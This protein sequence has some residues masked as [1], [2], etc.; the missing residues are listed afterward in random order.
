MTRKPNTAL[1][2]G[3]ITVTVLINPA[4]TYAQTQHRSLSPTLSREGAQII[5]RY[6]F[7]GSEKSKEGDALLKQGD[8]D[9]AIRMYQSSLLLGDIPQVRTKL[10]KAFSTKGDEN[11]ALAQYRLITADTPLPDTDIA[12]NMALTLARLR[13][14][15]EA[16]TMYR[17]GMRLPIT[18]DEATGAL[19]GTPLAPGYQAFQS[20]IAMRNDDD[21]SFFDLRFTAA[22]FDAKLFEAAIRTRLGRVRYGS[23]DAIDDFDKAIQL[24]PN[25]APAYLYRGDALKS[26]GRW[27]EAKAMYEKS[28]ALST[29]GAGERARAAL[30]RY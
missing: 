14:Y 27:E 22:N 19:L 29:S 13:K 26:G 20:K 23:R 2:T 7:R 6:M 18:L 17:V 28:A 25:F 12:L 10:A 16:F 3:I 5:A 11:A 15:D 4:V 8:V 21:S 9:G 1:I 30:N 24:S